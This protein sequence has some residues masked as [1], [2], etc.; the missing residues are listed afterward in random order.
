VALTP[1]LPGL[2]RGDL[3]TAIRPLAVGLLVIVAAQVVAPLPGPPLYDGVIP[4]EAYRWLSPPPGEHGGAAGVS[5]V[6]PVTGSVSPLIALATTELTPQAQLFAQ[7]GGL[8]MPAGTTSLSVAIAPVP[9]SAQ[10]ADGHI[11]GNVYR[12]TIATQ[13][14]DPVTAPASAEVTVVLRAPDPN[15]TEGTVALLIGGA[16]QPLKTD[17]AGLGASFV[18]VVTTFGDFAL[19]QSGPGPSTVGPSPTVGE[20]AAVAAVSPSPSGTGTAVPAAP[21]IPFVTIVA[22]I[23][24]I[25]VLAALVALA[26][27]PRRPPR[28]REWTQRR[29]RRGPR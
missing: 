22:G 20:S 27:L 17:A 6:V 3:A 7:P 2:G 19:L 18:T 13:A 23:A 12:I 4:I 25:L 9:P 24:T 28:R 15:A 29:D 11:A 8:T 26:V 10:P 21:G 1:G 16:W 5:V 14:G